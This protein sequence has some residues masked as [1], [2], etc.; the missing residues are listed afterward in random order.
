MIEISGTGVYKY[1]FNPSVAGLY[2]GIMSSSSV[3]TKSVTEIIFTTPGNSGSQQ[4]VI[5]NRVGVG[6]REDC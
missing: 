4:T 1:A 3:K 2:T 5:S 6:T